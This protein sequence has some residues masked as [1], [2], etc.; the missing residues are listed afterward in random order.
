MLVRP[1]SPI[2]A[3][4]IFVPTRVFCYNDSRA[5]TRVS[6]DLAHEIAHALLQHPPHFVADL[7][8]SSDPQMEEEAAFL[9]G[10]LLVPDEAPSG[11]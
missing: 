2:S 10:V 11:S 1:D 8:C 7:L 6:S 4:T 3:F 5:S 9:A